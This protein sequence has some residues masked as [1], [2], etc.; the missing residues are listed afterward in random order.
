MNQANQTYFMH[1][2]S[3]QGNENLGGAT[4][5]IRVVAENKVAVAVARC[6]KKDH[7]DKKMGRTIAE[8]RLNAM[9]NSDVIPEQNF[10]VIPEGASIKGTV[11]GY[12][13]P[14]LSEYGLV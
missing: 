9:L 8:G 12:L 7:F 5:A 14:A 13:Y 6:S 1:Y 10:V 2:R 11:D 3:G 4:V